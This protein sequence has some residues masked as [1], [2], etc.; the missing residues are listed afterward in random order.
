M[1]ARY[2]RILIVDDHAIMRKIIRSMLAEIGLENVDEAADG[3]AAI[4]KME[5]VNYAL[6]ISDWDMAPMDGLQLLKQIRKSPTWSR[7]PFIMITAMSAV[8]FAGIA[9]DAGATQFLPKPFTG[10]I[11]AERIRAI[12]T[13]AA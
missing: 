7:I 1:L 3:S 13:L 4:A 8:K 11:L 10:P 9:R 2:G 5:R 6:I 12:T